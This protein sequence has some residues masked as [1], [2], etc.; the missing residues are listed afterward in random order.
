MPTNLYGPGDN[1]D[2]KNS[3]VIPALIQRLHNAKLNKEPFIKVW[4]TGSPK[5]EFLYVDDLADACVYIM[6]LDKETINKYMPSKIGHINVG[7][8]TEMTINELARTLKRIVCY[9]GEII[10][11]SSKPDG[12]PR[13]LLD[14]SLIKNLGWKPK[15]EIT[16][17]LIK[18]YEAFQS[19]IN[20]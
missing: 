11:D 3:H 9:E 10:F 16:K 4:G 15:I 2:P 19:V 17:G 13:K 20:K 5:R 6:N 7:S 14:N 18:T 12:T 8:S 1:Y